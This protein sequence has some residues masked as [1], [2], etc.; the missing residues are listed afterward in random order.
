MIIQSHAHE[1]KP[2]A[3]ACNKIAEEPKREM[4]SDPLEAA[5]TNALDFIRSCDYI[6][7]ET[8]EAS[9]CRLRGNRTYL[10]LPNAFTRNQQ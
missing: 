7:D 2:N 4:A 10:K 6:G 3:L 9:K 5:L 8:R 1:I